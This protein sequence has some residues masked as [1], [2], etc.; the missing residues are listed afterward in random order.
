M[1]GRKGGA[2][3]SAGDEEVPTD[4]TAATAAIVEAVRVEVRALGLLERSV[5][6]G[7]PPVASPE[8]ER[9]V[10]AA[11]LEGYGQLEHVSRLE[12]EHFAS[13]LMGWLFE[14]LRESRRDGVVLSDESLARAFD[15][16]GFIGRENMLRA[17]RGLRRG[18]AAKVGVALDDAA[19]RVRHAYCI[20][21][22]HTALGALEASERHA[23][24]T[25]HA[26]DA[27]DALD[28]VEAVVA[29]VREL[30]DGPQAPAAERA[31]RQ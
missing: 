9:Q 7:P 11:L 15:T 17:L 30:V 31:D 28:R 25:G 27:H 14:V 10:V 8:C 26:L 18:V 22:L 21:R 12:R 20:R 13:P 5:A 16:Q 4:V 24:H 29:M 6:Y 1:L 2:A 23:S 19:T 3:V